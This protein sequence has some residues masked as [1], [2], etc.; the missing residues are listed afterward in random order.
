M[1]VKSR[2]MA[3]FQS[4]YVPGWDCHGLPIE[5]QVEK[6]VGKVGHKVDVATFR[7]Q[8]RE[9]ALQ[10]IDRQRADFKRLGVLGDWESPY[11]T[12]DFRYEADM[13]R[14]LAKIF[15]GG[16]ITSYNFV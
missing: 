2:L 10:Q 14:A 3:G 7:A 4:I 1:V 5:H 6:K 8:C 12:L 15:A 9:Y 13:V 16:H 11:A